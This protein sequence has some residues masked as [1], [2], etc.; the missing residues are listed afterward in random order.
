MHETLAR[1]QKASFCGKHFSFEH[2]KFTV[3]VFDFSDPVGEPG[4]SPRCRQGGLGR[5]CQDA[6]AAFAAR[7]VVGIAAP[8]THGPRVCELA[9]SAAQE[10]LES[11]RPCDQ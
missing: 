4:V 2:F 5:Q 9:K 1:F 10:E 11:R 3:F 8:I 6:G 7:S